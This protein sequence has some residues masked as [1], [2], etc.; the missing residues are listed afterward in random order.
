LYL[1]GPKEDI[2]RVTGNTIDGGSQSV[3][4]DEF[5]RDVAGRCVDRHSLGDN[6]QTAE[7]NPA[8]EGTKHSYRYSHRES[9]RWLLANRLL[10]S[11]RTGKSAPQALKRDLILKDLT[12]RLKSC[13]TKNQA[14]ESVSAGC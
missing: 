10:K 14:N 1:I 9:P 2:G 7:K 6:G 3:L 5:V 12:A 4:W 11:R 13:P 8:N